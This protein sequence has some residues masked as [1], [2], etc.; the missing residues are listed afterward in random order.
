MGN[1]LNPSSE[2]NDFLD[3]EYTDPQS[4]NRNSRDER[5]QPQM[6]RPFPPDDE[7]HQDHH[8]APQ[9]QQQFFFNEVVEEPSPNPVYFPHPSTPRPVSQLTEEEQVKIAQR[10]GLIQHLPVDFFLEGAKTDKE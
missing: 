8:Q 4:R 7:D 5:S 10:I 6:R 3:R 9:A 2:D 1:C